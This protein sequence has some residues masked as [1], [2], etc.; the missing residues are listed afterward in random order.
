[1]MYTYKRRTVKNSIDFLNRLLE[2]MPFP[3]QR[4][5][6]DRGKAFFAYSFQKQLKEYGIKFKPIK[7]RSLHLNGKA[8]RSHQT[9]LIEFYMK[10]D[11]KDKNLNDQLEQWQFHYNWHRPHSSLNGKTPMDILVE[12]SAKTPLGEDISSKYKPENEPYR[13]Q[14]YQDDLK[15]LRLLKKQ[16]NAILKAT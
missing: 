11:L 3:I 6:T 16:N 8:E 14:N 15:N 10:A 13:M 5:Q 1:M 2:Q 4:V 9:D 12:K 7:P